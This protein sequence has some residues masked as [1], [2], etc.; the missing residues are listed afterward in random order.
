MPTTPNYSQPAIFSEV[1]TPTVPDSGYLKVYAKSGALYSIDSAGTEKNYGAAGGGGGITSINGNTTAAQLLTVGT[2][3]TN[4]TIDSTTTPG[5][6]VFNIPDAS[7]TA[8][9]LISTG[10]QLI[11]GDKDFMGSISATNLSGTNSGDQDLSGYLTAYDASATYLTTNDASTTYVSSSTLSGITLNGIPIGNNPTFSV[12]TEGSDFTIESNSNIYFFSI[13]DAS[14]TARG[15]ITTGT[16]TIAGAKTFSSSITLADTVSTDGSPTALTLTG[17]AHT[18]LTLS[19]E[20]TDVNFNLAR[21]VQFATGALTTQ[22]AMRIQAPTYSFV[23]ASTITT[24][25][26]LSISGPPVA[27]TN[28]TITNAYALNVESG[29]ILL[30]TGRA[31]TMVND[32]YIGQSDSS[33]L[34]FQSS[35]TVRTYIRNEAGDQKFWF[36]NGASGFAVASTSAFHWSGLASGYSSPDLFL[37]RDAAGTLAQRNSTNAQTFR[38]YNTYISATSNEFLQIRG[39][40]SA[41]FEIG[42]QNASAGGTL[43]GLTLGGYYLGSSTIT[44]WLTFDN[45]GT[46]TF[47]KTMSASGQTLLQ[48]SPGNLSSSTNYLSLISNGIDATDFLPVFFARGTG[49]NS[50][51]GFVM[52]TAGSW[53]SGTVPAIDFQVRNAGATQTSTNR[54]AFAFRN[55]STNLLVLSVRGDAVLTPIAAT[56]GSPTALTITGAAH[57][58]LALSTEATDVNFNLARTVQFATGA[59]TTQRAMRI[60]APT[61]SF[62][63]ASTITT[64]STVS[65]SGPPVA[66]TNATITNA[67]ALNVES[68]NVNVAGNVLATSLTASGYIGVTSGGSNALLAGWVSDI[69]I[70]STWGFSW[71][72]SSEVTNGVDLTLLRDAAGILAQR[73]STNAQTFRVYNTY[74]SATSYERLNVRGVTSAN[75]EIGPEN[76]SAGG[77]LRGLTLGGY[78]AGST[79]I[80]PWLTF[81]N[82]GA[83]TFAGNLVVNGMTFSSDGSTSVVIGPNASATT[84]CVAIGRNASSGTNSGVAIG[85]GSATTAA[86]QF[87]SGAIGATITGVYFG[88]GATDGGT[89]YT[90]FGS[91]WI[92]GDGAGGSVTIAGGIGKGASVS[93]SVIISTANTAATTVTQTRT[94]RVWVL[95]GTGFVGIGTASP[96]GTLDIAQTI[97]T[98]GS[99]AVLN[100]TGGAHTTLTL[101]TEATDVN[102][103]LART[104]QFATGALTTQRAMRI[105]APTY[106]F[107]GASTITTASTLSISG[108]P[109]AGTNATITNA[110]ALNVESGNANFGGVATIAGGVLI[111]GTTSNSPTSST[112]LLGLGGNGSN[113]GW[114]SVRGNDTTQGRYGLFYDAASDSTAMFG[115]LGRTLTLGHMSFAGSYTPG[116]FFTANLLQQRSGTNAQT[117]LLYGTYTSSTS[118]ESL[119]IRG[120]ASANFEIGPANGSAGGTLRGLTLGGYSAGSTTITPWLSF[121][122]SGTPTFDQGTVVIPSGGTGLMCQQTN[123]YLDSY[124]THSGIRYRRSEGTQGSPTGVAFNSLVGFVATYGYHTGSAYHSTKGASIDFYATEAYTSGAQGTKIVFGTTP[125][126]TTTNTVALTIDQNQVATFSKLVAQSAAEI[127]STPSGTTQTI[128]LNNGNHQTLTLTSSTGTV[129]VTLTVPSNVSS[130]T[131]I[132]KQHGTTPRNITWAVSAG[133]IKWMGTQPTWSSDAANDIRI[134]SWRYDGSVMYLM[135]TDKA[136]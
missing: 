32:G 39:V 29:G 90:I 93:G 115:Y 120:V 88:S 24:A 16:Q 107:V 54:P 3:G 22:R 105:Q 135:S 108:A 102:F 78:S 86:S 81:T 31:V 61:Y 77:T 6:S 46:A 13:P 64:A 8:R 34:W 48:V 33:G 114:L 128:T 99:P 126:G 96:A 20:A 106:S 42:P 112:P 18:T 136:A 97:A 70:K 25:S 94:N 49:A 17:A 1:A 38:V 10:Y 28:A 130:G 117:F 98:T 37:Y 125:N 43:R 79:T 73:N 67:Y 40:A 127:T 110:Y 2:S 100:V 91:P 52:D 113:N 129:T 9:G 103:N 109:V 134:V 66:G 35:G 131:I 36:V 23:G 47:T 41:N 15:L 124:G 30:P 26:T 27:G 92:S 58:T 133:T 80:T 4:F 51:L 84:N 63:G 118:Y 83:A 7:E 56:S 123:I 60:Q 68:G 75:F 65:I 87:V 119:S 57:T 19:T 14:A 116:W 122:S 85:Y 76:G 71:A 59:I 55:F 101:S 53:S 111:G 89:G 45:V 50:G 69:R 62:V 82:A 95:A 11:A 132:V 74:A 12:G 72:S 104:V 5:T 44:P 121:T 21:T